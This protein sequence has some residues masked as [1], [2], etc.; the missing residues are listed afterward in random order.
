[1]DPRTYEVCIVGGGFAGL[2]TA[3]ALRQAGATVAVIERRSESND[4]HRGEVLRP[5]AVELLRGWGVPLEKGA[6]PLTEIHVE[7]AGKRIV[8]RRLPAGSLCVP[9]P[10][11][12]FALREAAQRAGVALFPGW[13]LQTLLPGAD[14]RLGGFTAHAGSDGAEFRAKLVV[15]ADGRASA[16][17]EA[18]QIKLKP[19][20]ASAE[21]LAFEAELAPAVGAVVSDRYLVQLGARGGSLGVPVGPRRMRVV[22]CPPPGDADRLSR[23]PPDLL[24]GELPT[25]TVLPVG[26]RI[27][28]ARLRAY[29]A[30]PMGHA[31]IY[32]AQGVV[33]VGE[34]VHPCAPPSGEGLQMA[35]LDAEALARHV[36]PALKLD[37]KALDK[38]LDR[39]QLER[40]PDNERRLQR[41]REGTAWLAPLDGV[42]R[43]LLRTPLAG[44]LLQKM[45]AVD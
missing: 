43:L 15:G 25:R 26:A 29:E 14:G 22:A 42:K 18:L 39:Y 33:L 24:A 1:M 30:A 20:P 4:P 16:V 3:L 37:A 23:Q 35:V 11:L 5:R 31:L 32:T 34:A 12:E 17:R 7:L 28:M 45:L 40:W 10:G 8:T 9:Q 27:D 21:L 41:A 38:G 36:G 44:L 6:T 19:A 13:R 2:T